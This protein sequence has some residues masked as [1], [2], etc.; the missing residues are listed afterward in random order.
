MRSKSG[1]KNC[2]VSVALC[3]LMA[4]DGY[5][6]QA[7][8][9]A[10]TAV[11]NDRG[12]QQAE[13][14]VKTDQEMFDFHSGF[15]MNL[16]HFLYQQALAQKAG[17]EGRPIRG[18]GEVAS[19]EALDDEQKRAWATALEHY[20]KNWIDRLPWLDNELAG[21]N[22]RLAELEDQTT[23]KRPGL[24][25]ELIVALERA[26]PIYRAHWWKEHDRI[27]RSW[28]AGIAPLIRKHGRIL[29]EQLATAYRTPW[30]KNPIR[31]EV[32]IYACWPG[33][34]TNLNPT[35]ITISSVDAGYQGLAAL[36]MIFHE[37]SHAMI[38]AVQQL[39]EKECAAQGKEPGDFWHAVLFYTIG[40]I[41]RRA[42][43]NDGQKDYEPY[44][45][46]RGIFRNYRQLMEKH[47][48]PYLDGKSDFAQAIK[49]MVADL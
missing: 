15:W 21:I 38:E 27:N 29:S 17:R 43:A 14:R 31:A 25:D 20:R 24:P 12:P 23:L 2:C 36:E 35:L 39:I 4:I 42:L 3:A 48:Q 34:Y 28:I 49:Q 18:A 22:S 47:W 33:A 37:A 45:Y 10:R 26:A 7:P 19:V 41:A 6:A 1:H 16:H 11:E 5:A 32:S 13:A 8:G 44:A 9:Q 30:A 40:A 46:K